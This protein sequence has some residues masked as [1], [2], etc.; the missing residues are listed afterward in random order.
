MLLRD[1]WQ[2]LCGSDIQVKEMTNPLLVMLAPGQDGSWVVAFIHGQEFN[3]AW[4]PCRYGF[5]KIF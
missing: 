2:D 1:L 4:A 5:L 3:Q